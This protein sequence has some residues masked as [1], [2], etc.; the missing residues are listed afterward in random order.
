MGMSNPNG[1][2]LRRSAWHDD[3]AVPSASS[4]PTPSSPG[5]DI[6]LTC[7][8]GTPLAATLFNCPAPTRAIMFAGALGVPRRFYAP[9]LAHLASAGAAVLTFDYRG[10]ADSAPSSLRGYDATLDDWADLDL[11][12][13]LSFL[14]SSFPS[15]PLTWIGHSMGGQLLGLCAA[16]V[17][18]PSGSAHVG[19]RGTSPAPVSHAILIAAQHGHWRNWQGWPRYAMAALWWLGIPLS[20]RLTGRL[21]MRTFGQ[22][23][24]A[25]AGVA[26]QWA[27]WGRSRDYIVGHARRRSRR[28]GFDSYRGSLVSYA[29]T[30]DTYAPPSTVRPLVAAFTATRGEYRELAP[31]DLGVDKIGHF[32]AFKLPQFAD[33]VIRRRE[34]STS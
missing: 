6:T 26:R 13:A 22:G 20:T 30:D 10:M 12:A 27:G 15:L 3:A 31:R 21:P 34:P 23:L 28:S 16:D 17:L 9:F 8:D 25:P 11:P 14:R 19:T 5:T 32:G 2:V 24:D 7:A 1:Q 29:I 33:E 18:S 4:A